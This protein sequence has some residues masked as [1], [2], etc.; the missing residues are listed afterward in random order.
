[1]E[2]NLFIK[3]FLASSKIIYGLLE[4]P[5]FMGKNSGF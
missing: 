5:N 1:M 2:S 3:Y 4:K